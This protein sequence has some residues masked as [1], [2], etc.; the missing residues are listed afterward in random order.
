MYGVWLELT[1]WYS[2]QGHSHPGWWYLCLSAC[3]ASLI[4]RRNKS[5]TENVFIFQADAQYKVLES[6]HTPHQQ[7]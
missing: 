5:E 1:V 2:C 3:C 6:E 4:L 7:I